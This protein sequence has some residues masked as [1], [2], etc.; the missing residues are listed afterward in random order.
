[1]AARA[2]HITVVQERNG[3]EPF[4]SATCQDYVNS[5]AT[6]ILKCD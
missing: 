2:A 5:A 3:V 6:V 1:L 4:G